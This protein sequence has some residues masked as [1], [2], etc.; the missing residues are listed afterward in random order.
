MKYVEVAGCLDCPYASLRGS[1]WICTHVALHADNYICRYD[2][3]RTTPLSNCPLPDMITSA[4]NEEPD[5]E[6]K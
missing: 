2:S 6:H 5:I 4:N 1:A 3:P